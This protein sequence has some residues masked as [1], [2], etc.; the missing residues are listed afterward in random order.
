VLLGI[1]CLTRY[2]AWIACPIL[3]FD[4]CAVAGWRWRRV[5]T[6]LCLFCWAPALWIAGHAGLSSPG[7]YVVE[8]PHSA[9][10]VVRWIYLGW[11]SV[12]DTAAPVVALAI[13]GAVVI[14]AGRLFRHRGI[15]LFGSFGVLFLIA[16]LCSAHGDPLPNTRDP[17]RFVSSREATLPIAYV[18]LL[19]GK[20]FEV[21][22]KTQRWRALTLWLGLVILAVGLLQSALFVR[23]E[24]S[25]PDVALSYKLAQYLD[26]HVG[27]GER[28]LILAK[29]FDKSDTQPILDKAKALD[30]A[31]GLAG[32]RRVLSEVDLSPL[33]FQRT[34]VQMNLPQQQLRST[35]DP[36]KAEWI[37]VWSDYVPEQKLEDHLRAFH[38]LADFRAA[39]LE[40]T[41]WRHT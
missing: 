9:A 38:I 18:L 35:G 5:V 4:Y 27:S 37:A 6:G 29:P 11:I 24:T 2:E 1:A 26:G 10:R 41:V 33:S 28:V 3:L 15:L 16:I 12:K 23:E 8:W 17:E 22:L 19:A 39:D 20:G 13:V 30:G 32:A 7:T 34:A 25:R 40:V 31:R 36:D 21:F 14:C